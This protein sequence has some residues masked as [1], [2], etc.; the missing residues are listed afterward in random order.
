MDRASNNMKIWIAAGRPRTLPLALASIGLGSFLAAYDRLFHWNVL[1]FA[2]LTTA[3]LQILSNLANDYGDSVHGADHGDRLC[4]MRAVQSGEISLKAMKA[5]MAIFVVLSLASGLWLLNVS[6]GLSGRVFAVFLVLGILAILAAIRYTNGQ[7]PYGYAGFGDLAVLLFFGLVGVLGTYY[8]HTGSIQWAYV[9]PALSCG[10]LATAVLN[11]NNIRDIESDY[12]AGK[13]SIPVRLG[14]KRAIIY[15]WGLLGLAFLLALL[16]V[17]INYSSPMQFL[18]VLSL[19][20][21]IKNGMAV[22]QKKDPAE[23]DPYLKQLALSTLV[24]IITFGIG[25]IL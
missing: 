23:L 22:A 25:L 16:F 7:N 19:P 8:L 20:L 17:W 12:Q 13:K 10:L 4:P 2:G 24:F 14:R 9:L 6:V 15:H 1:I 21:L 5:A 11:V 18:F 3:F